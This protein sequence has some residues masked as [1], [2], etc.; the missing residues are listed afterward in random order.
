MFPAGIGF[1]VIITALIPVRYFLVPLWFTPGEL[2]ILDAPTADAPSVLA[3]LGHE[4]ERVTGEG[5]RVAPD[6]ALA[7]SLWRAD[8]EYDDS[9]TSGTYAHTTNANSTPNNGLSRSYT[10][11]HNDGHNVRAYASQVPEPLLANGKDAKKLAADAALAPSVAGTFT[12]EEAPAYTI[13][14]HVAHE[15]SQAHSAATAVHGLRRSLSV[16]TQPSALAGSSEAPAIPSANIPAVEEQEV[17]AEHSANGALPASVSTA[18]VDSQLQPAAVK[19]ESVNDSRKQNIALA[20]AGSIT[21]K[22]GHAMMERTR[23]GESKKEARLQRKESIIREAREQE[24]TRNAERL[25]KVQEQEKA[26]REKKAAKEEKEKAKLAKKAAEREKKREKEIMKNQ[27]KTEALL[28]KVEKRK[29]KDAAKGKTSTASAATPAPAP[30]KMAAAPSAVPASAAIAPAVVAAP[31]VASKQDDVQDGVTEPETAAPN[32][33]Q[34]ELAPV[35]EKQARRQGVILD[36]ETSE[37]GAIAGVIPPSPNEPARSEYIA[38]QQAADALENN[39]A[40]ETTVIG[41]EPTTAPAT[42]SI[43]QPSVA[44]ATSEQPAAYPVVQKQAEAHDDVPVAAVAGGAAL[45]AVA[46]GGAAAAHNRRGDDKVAPVGAVEKKNAEEPKKKDGFLRRLSRR[47][48]S[49]DGAEVAKAG[50]TRKPA[51]NSTALLGTG[52]IPVPIKEE[53]KPSAKDQK[54]KDTAVAAESATVAAA[55]A[56]YSKDQDRREK[57]AEESRRQGGSALHEVAQDVKAGTERQ[58]ADDEAKL[59]KE[60]ATIGAAAAFVNDDNERLAKEDEQA[61]KKGASALHELAQDVKAGTE[62]H[63]ADEEARLQKEAATIGAAAIFINKDNEKLDKEDQKAR[64]QGASALHELAHEVKAGTERH[65]ADEEAR[66][67]KEAATIGAAAIFINKDNEKLDKEEQ[68]AR[69]K[70]ASTL[71]ELAQQVKSDTE[72]HHVEEEAKLQKEVATVGA[73]AVAVGQDNDKLAERE[74]KEKSAAYE[75]E[76]AAVGAAGALVGKDNRDL[77]KAEEKEKEKQFNDETAAVSLAAVN[78]QKDNDKLEKEEA[79]GRV[80]GGEA[81]GEIAQKGKQDQADQKKEQDAKFAAEA[82]SSAQ[83]QRRSARTT[84]I[85]PRKRRKAS[86]ALLPSCTKLHRTSRPGRRKTRSAKRRWLPLLP[87]RTR[88]R[89]RKSKSARPRKRRLLRRRRRRRRRRQRR[90]ARPRRRLTRSR[91]RRMPRRHR[92]EPLLPRRPR[93]PRM[94]GRQP[95]RSKPRRRR[96]PRKP[97]RQRSPSC[98]RSRPTLPHRL[99]RRVLLFSLQVLPLVLLWPG[100]RRKTRKTPNPSPPQTPLPRR[101]QPLPLFPRPSTLMP[102]PTPIPPTPTSRPM[103]LPKAI[104]STLVQRR[105]RA[106]L[107]RQQLQ[108]CRSRLPPSRRMWIAR[109]TQAP[110]LTLATRM[111]LPRA[112]PKANTWLS[113]RRKSTPSLSS[114]KPMMSGQTPKRALRPSM[115]RLRRPSLLLA[116]SRQAWSLVRL[117]SQQALTPMTAPKTS[118]PRLSRALLRLTPQATI[119][120]VAVTFKM[121]SRSP[122]RSTTM[123]VVSAFYNSRLE[124]NLKLTYSSMQ[125]R[126]RKLRRR[127]LPPLPLLLPLRRRL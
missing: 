107:R 12:D 121:P 93:R 84:K 31:I 117:W 58:H 37:A 24:S 32:N 44:D 74:E 33:T 105:R 62:R 55:V 81:L 15:A 21:A 40:G 41:T 51:Q 17:L 94:P 106:S 8:G 16:N 29:A 87:R 98:S 92:L 79:N 10:P 22:D 18:E 99:L 42:G 3:S 77:A 47:F 23:E 76:A 100:T 1:P 103:G 114:S 102:V 80:A 104:T 54:E 73:A 64:E 52:A 70:G 60:T 56:G 96:R 26:E 83:Q 101:R 90:L 5:L 53:N 115:R 14:P 75:R 38:R 86:I 7:G 124:D 66:L 61:R 109:A 97:P 19:A 11:E 111:L 6:T 88:R 9:D 50:E 68:K 25:A 125:M 126:Q 85:S 71:H 27:A 2:R 91:R 48:R 78:V 39:N 57:D 49:E 112:S 82:V 63:H 72:R 30:A 116:R 59:R 127:Q 120:R 28:A 89:R 108:W 35:S 118:S 34:Q 95:P 4:P 123:M 13:D 20:R 45:G 69:E 113:V 122:T 110:K 65:H 67:Q 36:P 119:P 43:V 46:V